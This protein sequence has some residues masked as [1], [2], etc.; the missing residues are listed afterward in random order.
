M[1]SGVS[2]RRERIDANSYDPFCKRWVFRLRQRQAVAVGPLLKQLPPRRRPLRPPPRQLCLRQLLPLQLR[3][4]QL[5]LIDIITTLP[6]LVRQD[7]EKTPTAAAK[8]CINE[9]NTTCLV[10]VFFLSNKL[11]QDINEC[12][13]GTHRCDP[14]IADCVNTAGSFR[15]KPLTPCH[16]T[17]STDIDECVEETHDCPTL[18]TLCV[19]NYGSFDCRPFPFCL[20]GH[21][22][23]LQDRFCQGTV[24]KSWKT[25]LNS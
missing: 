19:N 24:Y 1:F 10:L 12:E 13:E 20:P 5:D 6:A 16:P 21:R 15:C 3:L 8:V 9:W 11:F 4:Q 2:T 23:S 14:A 7:I 25:K 22:F 18:T 17:T